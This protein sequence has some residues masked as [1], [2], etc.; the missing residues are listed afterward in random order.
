MRL[1][2]I[3]VF[4]LVFLML[5]IL[6]SGTTAESKPSDTEMIHL[7]FGGGVVGGTGYMFAATAASIINENIDNVKISAITAAGCSEIALL[8]EAGE[9][10]LGVMSVNAILS[11]FDN[12]ID[13]ADVNQKVIWMSSGEVPYCALVPLDSPVKTFKDLQ[14]MQISV[15]TKNSSHFM[16]FSRV[17]DALGLNKESFKIEHMGGSDTINAYKEG[18]I[19]A[20]FMGGAAPASNLIEMATS[21][22][23][24]R[25]ISFSEDEI[26]KI[27]SKYPFLFGRIISAGT[28]KGQDKDARVIEEVYLLTGRPDIP[29]DVVYKIVKTLHLHQDELITAH[30]CG[31]YATPENVAKF[32]KPL[33]LHPGT[34]RYLKELGLL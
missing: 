15:G 28:Y 9:M 1:R 18:G 23:G 14:G 3:M 29:E 24:M 34:E 31:V 21:R 8:L 7:L 19:E 12:K 5:L 32:Y 10:D 27:T 11:G 13:L 25:I 30:P 2:K 22:R 33:L 20:V 4:S 16:I 26:V 6:P 17:I